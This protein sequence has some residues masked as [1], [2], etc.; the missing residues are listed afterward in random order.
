MA[1]EAPHFW[2]NHVWL[3]PR[4]HQ[5]HVEQCE[6]CDGQQLEQGWGFGRGGMPHCPQAFLCPDP[7]EPESISHQPTLSWWTCVALS[8]L[9]ARHQLGNAISGFDDWRWVC[10]CVC[11]PRV[12]KGVRKGPW[13]LA[14]NLNKTNF[15][16]Q[17]VCHPTERNFEKGYELLSWLQDTKSKYHSTKRRN[18]K[19]HTWKIEM[20]K[21]KEI[22]YIK[23]P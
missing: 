18:T 3:S 6:A 16:S 2:G 1:Q 9:G 22:C 19:Y 4:W 21:T 15:G 12:S 8:A 10:V 17:K 5:Q 11:V 7:I 23:M 14:I 20:V 13:T